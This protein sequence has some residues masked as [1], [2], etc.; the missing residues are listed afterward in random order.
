MKSQKQKGTDAA[1]DWSDI[2]ELITY[3]QPI[4]MALCASGLA[5]DINFGLDK[6][7]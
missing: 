2:C 4:F 1:P 5:L 7:T 3:S 6:A